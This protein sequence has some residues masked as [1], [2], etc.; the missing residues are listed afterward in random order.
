MDSFN[1]SGIETKT[2]HIIERQVKAVQSRQ[3]RQWLWQCSS[4]GLFIGGMLGCLLSLTRVIS[5]LDFSWL[6]IGLCVV[7]P[8]L[9]GIA[10]AIVRGRSLS[11]AARHIDQ[12]CGFKDRVQTAL[13]FLNMRTT[14]P[15]HRL[16]IE[17]ADS[18][19]RSIDPEKLTPILAPKYWN[20]GILLA[21]AAILLAFLSIPGIPLMASSESNPVVA[22]QALRASES[23]VALEQFQKEQND[24]ALEEML[25]DMNQQLKALH[26]PGIVP[27]EAMAKLSEMEAALQEMQQQL[28]TGSSEKQIKETGEAL[29]LSEAMAAAGDAMSKGDMQKAAAELSSMEMPKLDRKTEKAVTERL[30]QA[31]KNAAESPKNNDVRKSIEKMRQGLSKGDKTTFE[32]GARGLAKECEKQEQK[33][34]LSEMLQKQAQALGECKAECEGEARAVAQGPNKGGNKAGKG[35]GGDSAGEKTAK[36]NAGKEMKIAGQDSGEGDVDKT[37]TSNPEQEQQAVRE[38]RKNVGKYEAIQESALEAESIPLGHRQTIRRYFE[39]IRPQGT[40][41]DDATSP[42]TPQ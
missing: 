23:M 36:Q 31:E 11:S 27:K 13:H 20:F 26:Q 12:T 32:E 21:V 17:D 25:K 41:A 3:Q 42:E 15:L 22:E 9:A 5:H 6:W 1:W 35:S 28:T 29:S 37:T 14:D 33:T 39:L 18:H 24:P 19:L 10:V 40:E 4:S 7:A 16:Q 34:Q 2:M 8:T 30:E 38:Y